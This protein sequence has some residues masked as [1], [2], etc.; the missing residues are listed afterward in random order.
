MYEANTLTYVHEN[1]I[2]MIEPSPDET[3]LGEEYL[4]VHENGITMISPER[5]RDSGLALLATSP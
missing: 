1:G 3:P 2:T 5:V 4:Y